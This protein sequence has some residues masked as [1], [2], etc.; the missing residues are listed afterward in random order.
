MPDAIAVRPIDKKSLASHPQ[1]KWLETVGFR[2]DAGTFAFLPDRSVVAAPNDGDAIWRFAN[3]PMQLPEGA[4]RLEANGNATDVALGWSLGSYEFTRYRKPR[5]A[6]A[7][8]LPAPKSDGDEVRRIAES[9]FLARD[10][11]NTPCEDMGPAHLADAAMAVAKR[12]GAKAKTIVGDELLARN[13]PTIH[14]VGRAAAREPRLIDIRWGDAGDPKV[15]LVGKGVCFDTG[16]LDIKPREGM[17]DM[18]KD[19]GGAAVMLGLAQALMSANAPIRLRLLIPAVENSVSANAYRPLDIVRTR[20]GKTVEIGN[21]D[22]EGRLILCDALAEADSES[23]ELLI[24][25]ATL[26]GAAKIALGTEVQA[27]FC[28][29]DATAAAM[30]KAGFAVGDPLW[31][32]PIWR[33]YRKQIDGKCADLNNVAPTMM[34]GSIIG[35][36]YLAEFVSR[37]KVWAHLDIMAS[38]TRDRPGRPEG[39][40]ATAMRALYA[41]IRRRF[42]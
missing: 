37:A 36:L 34:G 31:R 22:A 16:G 19:M 24:D 40:E 38:N 27:L 20:A 18:K 39:G 3:L 42:G 41:Y 5:R 35:A 13:Y 33:P 9:V 8:L 30:M 10:L 7:K 21:T 14:I 6:P 32:L 12:F 4:Y 29:H 26:T 1:R 23:P 11:I 17:L 2:A 15:T 28:D 25:A